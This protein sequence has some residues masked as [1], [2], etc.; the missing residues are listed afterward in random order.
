MVGSPFLVFVLCSAHKLPLLS[1]RAMAVPRG[2]EF[3]Q[4][5]DIKAKVAS[6]HCLTPGPASW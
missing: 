6:F 1:D 3:G 4:F 5:A 2:Q